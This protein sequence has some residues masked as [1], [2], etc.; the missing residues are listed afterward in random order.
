MDN[1]KENQTQN[2]EKKKKSIAV[3]KTEKKEAPKNGEF[4]VAFKKNMKTV[5]KFIKKA[6][7]K[8]GRGL[9]KIAVLIAKGA[10]FLFL[11]ILMLLSNIS[12]FFKWLYKFEYVRNAT[13]FLCALIV[14][15]MSLGIMNYYLKPRVDENVMNS[16]S[17]VCY[18][19]FTE[20]DSEIKLDIN[21][22]NGNISLEIDAHA[23]Y[24]MLKEDE[25]IG[26]CIGVEAKGFSKKDKIKMMVG[27]D[28]DKRI[29]DVKVISISESIG[30][31]TKIEDVEFR[32][33]FIGRAD[34]VKIGNG[35]NEVSA[36]TGATISSKAVAAAINA[37]ISS[38]GYIMDE[39]G[40]SMYV[41]DKHEGVEEAVDDIII[42]I[43]E[44]MV[45]DEII[46]EEITD[47]A[48]EDADSG[49]SNLEEAEVNEA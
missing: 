49:E 40:K 15:V 28:T 45:G 38:I 24:R 39:D 23:I 17:K 7:K 9:K 5:L 21:D 16:A 29:V 32:R 4:G 22:W 3:N 27:I 31:G 46:E 12:K 6:A 2:P 41:P 11:M 13:I 8:I 30:L 43:N 19:V 47:F 33:N 14:L 25:V 10:A 34:Y 26:Y 20:A 36:A 42:N 37:V 48:I 35:G 44:D 18:E 1:K